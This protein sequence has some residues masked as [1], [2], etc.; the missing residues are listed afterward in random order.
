MQS[1][2]DLNTY[3]GTTITF[4]DPTFTGIIFDRSAAVDT[5]VSILEGEDF[6]FVPGIKA[7]SVSNPDV[8]NIEI[9][10]DV[11]AHTDISLTFNLTGTGVILSVV[12]NI[13]TLSNI[14]TV[15]EFDAAY[16][17][18]VVTPTYADSA[19]HDFNIP[20]QITVQGT[21]TTFTM[22]VTVQIVD[23]FSTAGIT[24]FASDSEHA[25]TNA[26]NL[27]TASSATF[28]VVLTPSEPTFVDTI[29]CA[30][31]LG[32]T[33]N[34]GDDSS[35][36]LVIQGTAAQVNDHLNNMT[37]TTSDLAVTG[38]T[39][40]YD[41]TNDVNA[42]G[43]TETQSFTSYEYITKTIYTG[44][45]T[46]NSL[47]DLSDGP[48]ISND[49]HEDGTVGPH[50]L[51]I[52]V[53]TGD[54]GTTQYVDL[55]TGGAVGYWEI[56]DAA[57]AGSWSYPNTSLTD[58]PTGYDKIYPI[59]KNS[60]AVSFKTGSYPASV[61]MKR[62]DFNSNTQAWE[63]HSTIYS[64]FTEYQVPGPGAQSYP[65]P[66]NTRYSS[67]DA[68][69]IFMQFYSTS[70][71]DNKILR[72]HTGAWDELLDGV[73]MYWTAPDGSF[74]ACD[75]NQHG[76]EKVLKWRGVIGSDSGFDVYTID[77]TGAEYT[78]ANQFDSGYRADFAGNLTNFK[79]WVWETP[80]AGDTSLV[81][82]VYNFTSGE[83]VFQ[84]TKTFTPVS[85]ILTEATT[86][87]FQLAKLGYNVDTNL[88]DD[89]TYRSTNTGHA[90]FNDATVLQP[91]IVSGRHEF[92]VIA[93]NDT[94]IFLT[95]ND[96]EKIQYVSDS[97]NEYFTVIETNASPQ[98][99]E[100]PFYKYQLGGYEWD[101]GS[102]ELILEGTKEQINTML[103]TLKA[104]IGNTND[105]DLVLTYTLDT[106]QGDTDQA[107]WTL[108]L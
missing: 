74:I 5:R 42:E 94:L 70:S 53:T 61:T 4:D 37:M 28:T 85:D 77:A 57:K 91:T 106:V 31:S 39:M 38:F 64:G 59:T 86:I 67:L 101:D 13:Y 92:Y 2:S 14:N 62:Y 105:D 7:I 46:K 100:Y 83:I 103:S 25:I 65:V 21:P 43:D 23:L 50:D 9:A 73:T 48:R 93:D 89:Q 41:A 49:A 27:Q 54:S 104:T 56:D 60:W 81:Y 90:Y 80:T 78:Q 19:N 15:E 98:V 10:F 108:S 44:T 96:E 20:T 12:N 52:A 102:G 55:S 71:T 35:D 63:E 75:S 1:M 6:A 33:F 84:E 16:S 97:G 3:G 99:L 82:D 17:P 34:Y 107:V 11:S 68:D 95:N 47:T 26:P 22:F 72:Y 66:T 24:S 79:L 87:D 30:G 8:A 88:T 51:T 36:Q 69:V 58:F 40:T 29:T 18:T 45:Y 76:A 32:G